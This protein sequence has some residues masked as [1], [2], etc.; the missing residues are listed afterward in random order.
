MLQKYLKEDDPIKALLYGKLHKKEKNYLE[1][2]KYFKK[3][4]D[5]GNEEAMYEYAKIVYKS[6]SNEVYTIS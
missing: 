1:A 6:Y 5:Q 4:I 3:A 2:I